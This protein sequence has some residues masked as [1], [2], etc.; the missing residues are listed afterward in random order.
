MNNSE[1]HQP[2]APDLAGAPL[3]RETVPAVGNRQCKYRNH[4]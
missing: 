1:F 4:L 3:A 2:Q